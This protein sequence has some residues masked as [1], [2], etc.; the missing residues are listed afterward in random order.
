MD[1]V[2]TVISTYPRGFVASF[3]TRQEHRPL[4]RARQ[5]QTFENNIA[6]RTF[7]SFPVYFSHSSRNCATNQRSIWSR[8][9]PRRMSRQSSSYCEALEHRVGNPRRRA[10]SRGARNSKQVPST[11]AKSI[12]STKTKKGCDTPDGPT[13]PWR[14]FSSFDASE[15]SVATLRQYASL[16][17]RRPARG[18]RDG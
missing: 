3:R 12:V 14:C 15:R 11:S 18:A 4:R 10:P 8:A 6:L 17:L 16:R 7:D 1:Y 13:P 5:P 9:P 2:R